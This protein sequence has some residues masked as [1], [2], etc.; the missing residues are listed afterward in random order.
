MISG[1]R[2]QGGLQEA[3]RAPRKAET[4]SGSHATG[5]NGAGSGPL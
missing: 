3:I 1:Q 2:A 5:H 4:N